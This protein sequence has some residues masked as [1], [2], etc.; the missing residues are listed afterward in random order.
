[1]F[2]IGIFYLISGSV[3]LGGDSNIA[4]QDS[5][6]FTASVLF[7][8]AFITLS[9]FVRLGKR[10]AQIL[11]AVAVVISPILLGIVFLLSTNNLVTAENLTYAAPGFSIFESLRRL[12][13]LQYISASYFFSTFAMP[14]LQILLP[15]SLVASVVITATKGPAQQL[16]EGEFR[17][18]GQNGFAGSQTNE[19]KW[20]IGLPGFSDQAIG[21]PELR[22]FVAE[23][24]IKADSPVRDVT[25]GQV[26]QAKMVSGL[27]S[28]RD[29]TTALLLSIFLGGLGVDRFYLGQTG[30]G[31]GKLLTAGGCGIWSLI[32]LILIAMRKVTDNEGLP[33]G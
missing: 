16:I 30:L 7:A 20:I 4:Y 8:A 28:K 15:L 23:G 22:K 27:F 29:Y 21:F 19:P 26:F 9:F 10:I 2:A 17:T 31:I 3:W 5:L 14:L 25:S 11:A 1:L 18:T 13:T 6:R 24:L 12:E 33:L 32:D